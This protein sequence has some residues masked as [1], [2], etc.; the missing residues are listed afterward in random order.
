L[1]GL[2]ESILDPLQLVTDEQLNVEQAVE[3][4]LISAG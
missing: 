4:A 1:A 3:N 2:V